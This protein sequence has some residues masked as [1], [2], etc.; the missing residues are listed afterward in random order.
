[1]S[2][3]VSITEDHFSSALLI[4]D[5]VSVSAGRLTLVSQYYLTCSV[6]FQ[7]GYVFVSSFGTFILTFHSCAQEFTPFSTQSSTVIPSMSTT[8][9]AVL[10]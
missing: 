1:M 2:D 3:A 10:G 8:H 5:L 6:T 4:K 7:K 9:K